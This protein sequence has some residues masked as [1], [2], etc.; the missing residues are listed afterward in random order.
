MTNTVRKLLFHFCG[1]GCNFDYIC[2]SMYIDV[3]ASITQN[4][5]ELIHDNSL[6]S[7]Q[8]NS[9]NSSKDGNYSPKSA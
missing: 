2:E 1:D 3:H 8:Y 9:S 6:L 5:L 4:I 7:T